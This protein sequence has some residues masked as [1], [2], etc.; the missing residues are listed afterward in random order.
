MVVLVV[1]RL[2]ESPEP[3][4]FKLK[5]LFDV[6]IGASS[7][8]ILLLSLKTFKEMVITRG[9]SVLV[10]RMSCYLDAMVKFS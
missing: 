2:S 5:L 8:C 4:N 10:D 9:L 3:I 1:D 6:D 7:F